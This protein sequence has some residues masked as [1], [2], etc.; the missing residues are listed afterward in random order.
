MI[1]DVI[2]VVWN[3]Q[4]G[5]IESLIA[6]KEWT[7]VRFKLTKNGRPVALAYLRIDL[8]DKGLQASPKNHALIKQLA[9]N[10]A[11]CKAASH[12]P[13]NKHRSITADAV[14]NPAACVIQDETDTHYTQLDGG[15]STQLYGNVEGTHHA[16]NPYQRDLVASFDDC[17]DVRPLN[18]RMRVLQRRYL[19][20]NHGD[21]QKIRPAR[22]GFL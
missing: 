12:L 15:F 20:V 5:I 17:N 4:G 16:L 14:I 13:Q 9:F 19:C 1:N 10:P 2:P 8:S 22:F 21:P 7:S 11:L 3:E 6:T 18:F